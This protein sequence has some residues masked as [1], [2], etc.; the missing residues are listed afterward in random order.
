[1]VARGDGPRHYA[2]SRQH[3]SGG[4]LEISGK[5]RL[6]CSELIACALSFSLE[7][8]RKGFQYRANRLELDYRGSRL[9]SDKS[10][11]RTGIKTS[12]CKS[13]LQRANFFV[14]R[15]TIAS[16]HCSKGLPAGVILQDGA[17]I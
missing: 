4:C 12:F 13:R 2:V 15:R 16:G 14:A 6:H 3:W 10:I 11:N 1:M 9:W 7:F 5:S 17:D 8:R